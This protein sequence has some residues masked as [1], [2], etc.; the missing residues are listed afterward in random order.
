M[1]LQRSKKE[2]IHSIRAIKYSTKPIIMKIHEVVNNEWK[3]RRAKKMN[4]D[5]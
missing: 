1:C 4:V 2:D 3:L 5:I